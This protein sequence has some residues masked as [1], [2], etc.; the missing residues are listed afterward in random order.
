MEKE[1]YHISAKGTAVKCPAKYKCRM[2]DMEKD[3]FDSK[4]EAREHFEFQQEAETLSEKARERVLNRILDRPQGSDNPDMHYFKKKYIE[5]DPTKWDSFDNAAL[6]RAEKSVLAARKGDLDTAI[7][8]YNQIEQ[9]PPIRQHSWRSSDPGVRSREIKDIAGTEIMSQ[10]GKSH[11]PQRFSSEYEKNEKLVGFDHST[12]AAV[13]KFFSYGFGEKKVKELEEKKYVQ[14]SI[15]R[16]VNGENDDYQ[17]HPEGMDNGEHYESI[18]YLQPRDRIVAEA[19]DN[20]QVYLAFGFP[21]KELKEEMDKQGIGNV[22]VSFMQNGRENG[23]TYTVMAPDASTRTFVVYEHRN[24][25][26]IVINGKQNWDGEGLPYSGDSKESFYDESEYKDYTRVAK[27]LAFFMKEAQE[28]RLKD[29]Q[30]LVRNASRVDYTARIAKMIPGFAEF[31]ER[32]TGENPLKKKT[33][34][35]ILKDLDLHFDID[36]E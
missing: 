18:F 27:N 33:D 19:K 25:D 3:H 22:F 30:T 29:D 7:K 12:D 5:K 14:E 36:D 17:M 24:K 35:E 15:G 31:V 16:I 20:Q 2:G 10:W 9:K 8:E 23:L 32:Q 1:R 13:E 34:E 4:E 28:G 26:S 6:L 21:H 11:T